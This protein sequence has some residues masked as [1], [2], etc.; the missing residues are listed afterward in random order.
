MEI[1]SE[2]IHN[3]MELVPDFKGFFRFDD[4]LPCDPFIARKI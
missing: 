1:N 4:L 3:L 2:V